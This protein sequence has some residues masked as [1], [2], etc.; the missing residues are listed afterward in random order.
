[1]TKYAILVVLLAGISHAQVSSDCVLNHVAYVGADCAAY[2]NAQMPAPLPPVNDIGV[3]IVNAVR[4]F[5]PTVA[6]CHIVIFPNPNPSYPQYTISSSNEMVFVA[7]ET[8]ECP[9]SNAIDNTTGSDSGAQISYTG[10]GAAVTMNSKGGRFIGCDLLLGPSVSAGIVMGGYSNYARD[11]GVRGGGTGTY[12]VHISGSATE[13]NH[14]ENSRIS[15]FIG[16]GIGIDHANDT[17]VTDVTAYG[18]VGN[19]TGITVLVD[20]NAGGTYFTNI[21]GG[22]SGANFFKARYSGGNYP[23]Y[24]FARNMQGDLASSDAYVFDSTLSSANVDFTFVDCWA[25][26]SGGS[27]LHIS[28]GSGIRWIGGKIRANAKDGVTIDVGA[29]AQDGIFIDHSLIEGNNTANAGYNGVSI[30]GHPAYVSVIGNV[31][32]NWPEASGHQQYGISTSSDVEG[33]I[34]ANNQCSNNVMGCSNL[35][36]VVS[37]KLTYFGNINMNSGVSDEVNYFGGPIVTPGSRYYGIATAYVGSL[38]TAI[39]LANSGAASGLLRLRDNTNGG[40]AVFL[41]DPNAGAQLLGTSQIS[42]ITSSSAIT[43]SGGNWNVTLS[44]GNAPRIIAWTI[45]D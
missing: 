15:D 27:G 39:Q 22:N 36:S 4:N 7:N 42:G 45:Y 21:T 9:A 13:D 20:S 35:S 29:G 10:T 16:V 2:W 6:Q 25:A 19:T 33:L 23:G 8:V 28:G 1:M 31:I 26:G 24:I 5:C 17:F 43:W 40:S 44:A 11:V 34:F 32:Q 18:K 37:T 38:H 3:Q 30:S 14:L 41:I 12:M